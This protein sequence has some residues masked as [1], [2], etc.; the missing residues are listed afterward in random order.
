MS[1]ANTTLKQVAARTSENGISSAMNPAHYT[2]LTCPCT[3]GRH[4]GSLI[5]HLSKVGAFSWLVTTG[6]PTY[7]RGHTHTWKGEYIRLYDRSVGQTW[8]VQP[9]ARLA[10]NQSP[11]RPAD[12]KS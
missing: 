5:A 8:F 9:R 4:L 2:F 12:W 10:F 1:K 3:G 6:Q 7:G 11:S